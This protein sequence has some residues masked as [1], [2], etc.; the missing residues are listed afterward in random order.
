MARYFLDRTC[1]HIKYTKFYKMNMLPL[2]YS[3]SS[4][5]DPETL[6]PSSLSFCLSLLVSY[7]KK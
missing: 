3:Q 2:L 7:I 5:I 6:S 1:V 4:F